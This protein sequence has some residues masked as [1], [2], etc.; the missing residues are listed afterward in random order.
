VGYAV[1]AAG[2]V[3]GDG[4]GDLAVGAPDRCNDLQTRV[5]VVFGRRDLGRVDLDALGSGG[6][7]IAGAPTFDAGR[8]LA[9]AGDVNRD[10]IP[11][12]ALGDPDSDPPGRED[13]GS[14]IV[15]YG[16]RS[17]D[18]IRL[19]SLGAG[20]YR[21]LGPEPGAR[22]GFWLANAGDFDGD[23]RSDLLASIP[24][25]DDFA[26]GAWLLPQP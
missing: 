15:V 18:P 13:A 21:W 17:A 22:F 8:V 10:G 9:P 6:Y 14:V 19:R 12:L 23:G 3:N 4:I 24:R 2:D 20:G 11:D 25:R 7:A 1:S 5:F 26:G 16:K